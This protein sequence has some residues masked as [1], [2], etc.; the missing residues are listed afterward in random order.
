[1]IG[2]EEVI[3]C[4]ALNETTTTEIYTRPLRDGLATEPQE[5]EDWDPVTQEMSRALEHFR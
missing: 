4:T 1:M 5:W 2:G 3:S